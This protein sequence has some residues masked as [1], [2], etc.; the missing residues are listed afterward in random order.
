MSLV[1]GAEGFETL[2]VSEFTFFIRSI[3][4]N[5]YAILTLVMVLVMIFWA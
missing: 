4:Y 2:G 1:K 5:I 3:P